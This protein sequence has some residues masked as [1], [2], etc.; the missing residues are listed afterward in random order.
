M[1][2]KWISIL[3]AAMLLAGMAGCG[4]LPHALESSAPAEAEATAVPT[5][6]ASAEPEN[7]GYYDYLKSTLL[8]ACGAAPTAPVQLFAGGW[9]ENAAQVAGIL[10]ADVRDY[11]G[12]GV[13]DM[14]AVVLTGRPIGETGL[15]EMVYAADSTCLAAE[16]R[17]YTVQDGEIRLSDTVNGAAE[18]EAQSWGPMAVGV[19]EVDGV[20][21][22]YGYSQ[23]EDSTT[24]G[25]RPFA[26]YHVENGAFVFDHI[27]GHIG[28][29]QS[30][31]SG[32]PNAAA[33]TAGMEI[34]DTPLNGTLNA[35][36]KLQ[37]GTVEDNS[38]A[39][40]AL[41][42]TPLSFIAMAR[43]GEGIA[44][45]AV[46]YTQME[47]ICARG[48]EVVKAERTPMPSPTPEPEVTGMEA[49]A[50]A[51]AA[52]A[53]QDSGFALEK[54]RESR[55]EISYIVGYTAPGGTTLNL[56]Y[57][58][59]GDTEEIRSISVIAAGADVTAEWLAL[60][61]AVLGMESLG[62]DPEKVSGFLG[63]CGFSHASPEDAGANGLIVLVGNAG[64][65]T[66]MAQ[67]TE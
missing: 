64:S 35:L 18:M 4:L 67:W 31:Y 1:F 14:L 56:L 51:I 44:Y 5:P 45:Q 60:K 27:G 8:P 66:M 25:A 55:D 16:L 53:A 42:G 39:V 9:A 47:E 50:E 20:P 22:I 33:G 58:A 11:D 10:S 43:D 63:D 28:W 6:E 15:G 46:D 26:V 19:Q 59:D 48:E 41:Y 29:G 49:E 30:S 62:F 2:K 38:D 40:F 52:Q 61:D 32:D 65:C 12:D 17:L 3:L 54:T 57:R 34:L 21:Y 37:N 7:E 13:R 24:Y 23:M 36:E